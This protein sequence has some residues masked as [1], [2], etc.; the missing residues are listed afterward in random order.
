MTDDETIAPAEGNNDQKK[1]LSKL[2]EEIRLP[3]RRDFKAAAD[4][5]NA[6]PTK[7]EPAI[8]E[9]HVVKGEVEKNE[10]PSSSIV[11]PVRTLKD[12]L[13]TVVRE[14]K[15]S[16]V[17]AATLEEEKKHG[18]EHLTP[19]QEEIR[20][21]KTR[22]IAGILFASGI[23][24]LL[25]A[26]AL[27]GVFF[28]MQEQQATAPAAQSSILFAEQTVSFPLGGQSPQNL[29][30]E[31]AQA[32]TNQLGTL[33]SITR[34]VPT[35]KSTS[36]SGSAQTAP[37]TISQFFAALGMNPPQELMGAIGPDFFLGFHVVDTNA[38]ILVIPVSS[39]DHAFAGMLAWEPTMNAD[40]SPIFTPVSMTKVANG[41]PVQRTFTDAVM[42]NYD[43]RQLTDDSGNV[44]LYYSFPT[45]NLL[46]IAQS[47]YSFTELLS[48]LQAAREL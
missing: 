4:I 20:T 30:D 43:V 18:Q 34:V 1:D 22:R 36:T 37:A 27:F 31:L 17:H 16:L 35:I 21:R 19:E 26:G 24:V 33:G 42:R 38:P 32:R 39:Y 8:L 9:E 46:V 14:Q 5:P 3:E 47:P 2:L 6:P 28:V 7:A 44:V 23:L 45:P 41:V 12:D 29:K 15:I 25:G 48:R 13:Q 11:A 10:S 40:L